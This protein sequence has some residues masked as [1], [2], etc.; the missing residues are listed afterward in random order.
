MDQ[1]GDVVRPLE[2][3]V[4]I[5]PYPESFVEVQVVVGSV[6]REWGTTDI[7]GMSLDG[8]MLFTSLVPFCYCHLIF[9]SFH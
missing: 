1:V 9:S 2:G 4:P 5:A 3:L 6:R 7:N 8:S